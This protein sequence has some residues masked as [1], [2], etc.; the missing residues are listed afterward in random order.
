M[1]LHSFCKLNEFNLIFLTEEEIDDREVRV[2]HK[3]DATK[4][5][6]EQPIT[7]QDAWCPETGQHL[8][9]DL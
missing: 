4:R 7:L 8:A 6:S 5:Y 1:K 2:K 3:R 9:K